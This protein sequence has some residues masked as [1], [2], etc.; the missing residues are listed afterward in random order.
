M[1]VIYELVHERILQIVNE[2]KICD[3]KRLGFFST[4]EICNKAINYYVKQPGFNQYPD[5]F[6]MNKIKADIDA[7]NEIPGEFEDKVYYL[8]HEWYDG[9][10]D[11]VTNIGYYSTQCKAESAKTLMQFAEEFIEHQEGFIVD[12]YRIDEMEWKEGFYCWNDMENLDE[13]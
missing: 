7:Y 3:I 11:Y 1:K 12:E 5:G 10:Y 13:N 9:E 2:E 8:S 6:V 4:E